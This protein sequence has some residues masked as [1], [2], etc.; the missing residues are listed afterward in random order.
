MKTK[1]VKKIRPR[2]VF[3]FK[4][5]VKIASAGGSTIDPTTSVSV[6]TTGF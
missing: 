5:A 4:N 3:K 2:V 6:T 1:S